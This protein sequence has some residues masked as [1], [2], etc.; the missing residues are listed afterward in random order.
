MD[1]NTLFQFDYID[2][3]LRD[4]IYSIKC[5]EHMLLDL[6]NTLFGIYNNQ[7]DEGY[8]FHYQARGYWSYKDSSVM[9]ET[10]NLTN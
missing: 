5:P 8:N 4:I 6:D 7:E 10:N 2:K 3:V 1:A 9:L